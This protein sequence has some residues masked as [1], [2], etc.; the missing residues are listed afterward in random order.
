MVECLFWATRIWKKQ[1]ASEVIIGSSPLVSYQLANRTWRPFLEVFFVLEGE[2]TSTTCRECN[3]KVRNW[4]WKRQKC[5]PVSLLK[6]NNKKH[7][8]FMC[9]SDSTSCTKNVGNRCQDL[10]RSGSM[11]GIPTT[12]SLPELT[13][14]QCISGIV[15]VI[16]SHSLLGLHA[17]TIVVAGAKRL[18]GPWPW[19][20]IMRYHFRGELAP[21]KT[22]HTWS[23]QLTSFLC[24]SS[25]KQ[26]GY[27]NTLM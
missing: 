25:R 7:S 23:Q 2:M 9:H 5:H 21:L 27:I 12:C 26:E 20:K 24:H 16:T 11:L 3:K 8:P 13:L 19:G 14:S 17:L 22:Q 18:S 4:K 10:L 15:Q 1:K 6:G